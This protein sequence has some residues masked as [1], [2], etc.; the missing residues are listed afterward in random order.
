MTAGRFSKAACTAARWVAVASIAASFCAAASTAVAPTRSAP[1]FETRLLLLDAEALAQRQIAV[2]ERG[3][4]L[5]RDSKQTWRA[6]KTIGESTLTALTRHGKQL[7][8]VGHDATI[9]KSTDHAASWQRVHYAPDQQRPLLD[10]LFVNDAHGFAVGAYG[11]FLETTDG[12]AHWTS[13][14]IAADDRHHNAIAALGDGTLLIAGETGTLLRSTDTGKT[15]QAITSPYAGSWFGILPVGKSGAVIFGLRGKL[16]RTDDAGA[17]WTALNT[18][19]AAALMGGRVLSNG[20]VMVVGHDGVVLV[21]TDHARSFAR[22]QI[23]GN[24][25]LSTVFAD[26]DVWWLFGERGVTRARPPQ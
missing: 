26:G 9:L 13:R 14:S 8:A 21:S 7:W 3:F 25:A 17:Y 22:Y 11:Y 15:W 5:Y 20:T 4:I 16:Y 6:A 2:G 23:P 18:R 24:A 19:T 10:V 1:G 12:G